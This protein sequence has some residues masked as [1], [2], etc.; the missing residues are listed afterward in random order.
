VTMARQTN[1]ASEMTPCQHATE[2][3]TLGARSWAGACHSRG[4]VISALRPQ[5]RR[6]GFWVFIVAA[7]T[8]KLLLI[9]AIFS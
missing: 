4:F 8:V 6:W 7:L 1:V 9:Y 2:A 3:A 5:L